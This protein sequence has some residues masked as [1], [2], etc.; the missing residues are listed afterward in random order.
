MTVALRCR[1]KSETGLDHFEG[2]IYQAW[3]R[4]LVLTSLSVLFLGEQRQR[5]R[6]HG[7][8]FTLE[9]VKDAV[10]VQLDPE[11]PRAE[12]RRQLE[13]VLTRILYYQRRNAAARRS[14][15][16]T[17]LKRLEEAGVDFAEVHR[18][19]QVL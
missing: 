4:H 1:S 15:T 14:H 7:D 16:K 19:P 13:K 10:E 2:R 12:V 5:L 3:R 17:R 6:A 8:P 18:C 11:M 9:Q